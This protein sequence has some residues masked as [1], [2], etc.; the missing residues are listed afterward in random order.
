MKKSL[1]VVNTNKQESQAVAK[2]ISFYLQSKKIES[3]IC[4]FDG[5]N[6]Q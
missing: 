4:S 6:E 3:E 1:I 5:F 2:D